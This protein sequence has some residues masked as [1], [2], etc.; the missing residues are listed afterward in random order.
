MRRSN[1]NFNIPN[2]PPPL[3]ELL[4]IRSF[5]FP[6]SQAKMAF[7]CHTLPSDFVCQMALLKNNTVDGSWRLRI[8]L[9]YIRGKQRHQLKME[10][11]FRCCL[12]DTRYALRTRNTYHLVSQLPRRMLFECRV[13]RLQFMVTVHCYFMAILKTSADTNAGQSH[14]LAHCIK[15]LQCWNLK[16]IENKHSLLFIHTFKNT[17]QL[18]KTFF[19]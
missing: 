1:R 6:P 7:K 2:P 19:L 16:S 17:T 5:K 8:K 3:H 9:V 15:K 12:G 11:Y 10:N 18:L 14:R 13:F 4:K